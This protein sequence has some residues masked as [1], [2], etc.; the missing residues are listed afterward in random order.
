MA[1]ADA[2]FTPL[3]FTIDTIRLGLD[4]DKLRVLFVTL[5]NGRSYCLKADEQGIII[6]NHRMEALAT[7]R[8]RS[9]EAATA[10]AALAEFYAEWLDGGIDPVLANAL[11]LASPA[12]PVRH[13]LDRA[14]EASLRAWAAAQ[15]T[16]RPAPAA[17]GWAELLITPPGERSDWYLSDAA[18]EARKEGWDGLALPPNESVVQQRIETFYRMQGGERTPRHYVDMSVEQAELLRQALEAA[19]YPYGGG[20]VGPAFTVP[21]EP[22][23]C[24]CYVPSL[25]ALF[26]HLA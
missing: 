12:E 5:G 7:N 20:I 9:E 2:F 3:M 10:L 23:F 14:Q 6:F 17:A 13:P 16:L 8:P 4:L 19:R 22:G 21:A 24:Y 25:K 1:E 15:V 11:G 18:D 26:Y